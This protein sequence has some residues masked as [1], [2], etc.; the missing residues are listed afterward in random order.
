MEPGDSK[1]NGRFESVIS[2]AS[3]VL[4]LILAVGDRVSKLIEPNDYEY[5][6]VRDEDPDDSQ[7]A[8][9]RGKSPRG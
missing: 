9:R 4:D 3:P 7:R 5:Y 6:P 2:A 1:T 8:A